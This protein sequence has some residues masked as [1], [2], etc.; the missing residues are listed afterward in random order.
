MRQGLSQEQLKIMACAS[1]LVDHIGVL[2]FPEAVWL[3]VLGRIA[4]PIYCFL[5]VEGFEKTRNRNKYA[6]RLLFGAVLAELPY[7]FAFFG[8]I[9]WPRQ[10]VMVTLV[11]GFGVLWLLEQGKPVWLILPVALAAQGLGTDYGGTGIV[12][13]ALI[14]LVR[15]REERWLL[16]ALMAVCFLGLG[17]G[18]LSVQMFGVLAVFPIWAYNG[19]KITHSALATWGFYLFYPVHLL[20]LYLIL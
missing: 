13:I 1:M 18:V 17:G 6:L 4:F 20:V 14:Y 19:R 16:P 11:M 2:F 15:D 7:D 9:Y 5:L 12:L 8:G 3:R 10:S